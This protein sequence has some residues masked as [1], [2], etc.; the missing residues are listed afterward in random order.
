MTPPNQP[1]RCGYG[2]FPCSYQP[3]PEVPE[4]PDVP[5]PHRWPLFGAPRCK[6]QGQAAS[7]NQ[8]MEFEI[9]LSYWAHL[10]PHPGPISPRYSPWVSTDH[11]ELTW[12]PNR[13]CA[14]CSRCV[15]PIVA[16]EVRPRRQN[17]GVSHQ[18][19][20][21]VRHVCEG[22]AHRSV[23]HDKRQRGATGVQVAR[24]AYPLNA[25]EAAKFM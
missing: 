21:P 7:S 23:S 18:L 2:P 5:G 6:L 9:L 17:V 22:G 8:H 4:L 19:R 25:I 20:S 13:F 14:S 10:P 12:H 15:Q 3:G 1:K 11:F 24:T 16:L